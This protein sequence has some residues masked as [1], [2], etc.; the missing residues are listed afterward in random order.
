MGLLANADAQLSRAYSELDYDAQAK[1][2][3]Y[4]EEMIELYATDSVI[5]NGRVESCYYD[6]I[7]DYFNEAGIE[8]ILDDDLVPAIKMVRAITG[9]GLTESYKFVIE[10]RSDNITTIE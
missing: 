1:G 5:S 2:E 4:R 9:Y 8:Y 3:A 10:L 6:D 7:A